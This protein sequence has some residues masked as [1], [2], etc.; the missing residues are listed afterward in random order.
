MFGD[1][2]LIWI[3]GST[4]KNLAKVFQPVLELP[5][6]DAW[7]LIE[8]GNLKKSSA[9]RTIVE[10]SKSGMAL[11][12][13]QD[14]ALAIDRLIDE[15]MTSS[16]LQIENDAKELL[17]SRLGGDRLASRAEL[18]KLVLFALNQEIITSDDVIAI[19]GDAS[20]TLLDELLDAVSIGDIASMQTFLV[21]ILSA[22][23]TTATVL[24]ALTRHFQTLHRCRSAMEKN[25]LSAQSVVGGLRPMI[26]FKRKTAFTRSLQAWSRASLDKILNRLDS[27]SLNARANPVLSRSLATMTLLAIAIEGRSRLS[28]R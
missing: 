17:K 27:V 11:P 21:R 3:K 9:L 6:K 23:T 18:D 10:K 26:S 25:R 12:C 8:A 22:G 4:R 24:I 14:E 15:V 5:P 2:R 7:I 13:Y 28:R 20:S 19:V 1:A 16:G